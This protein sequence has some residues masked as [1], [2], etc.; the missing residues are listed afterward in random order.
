M[1]D[2]ASILPQLLVYALLL[3][4]AFI[5]FRQVRRLLRGETGCVGCPSGGECP[6]ASNSCCDQK[7]ESHKDEL[8]M[9]KK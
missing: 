5:L 8:K 6:M 7:T 4:A 3:F 9:I 2:I 1:V